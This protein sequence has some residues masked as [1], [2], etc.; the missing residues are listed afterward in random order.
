M[1]IR[2]QNPHIDSL[3]NSGDE[4]KI[5]FTKTVPN[6]NK[7]TAVARVSC[8][9]RDSIKV[10]RNRVYIG[11]SSCRIFDRFFVKPCNSCQEFGHYKDSFRNEVKCGYCGNN[12]QS[13]QCHLRNATDFS[14]LKCCNC[15][16]NHPDEEKGHSTFWIKCPSYMAA[17]KKLRS[18]IP[19]YE[20]LND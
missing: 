15:K 16:L 19:Y 17:Q 11:I 1:K 6:S 9:I 2:S 13:D 14:Q 12:H 20:G 7:Y 18:R 3:I 10:H 8:K 4:F 5:L